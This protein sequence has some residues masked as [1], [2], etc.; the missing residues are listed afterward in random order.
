[1]LLEDHRADLRRAVLLAAHVDA[2]V[3]VGAGLDLV[4][5]DRLL[6]FDLSLLAAHEALDR[7]D[8][9]LGVHHRLPFGDGADQ[10]LTAVG[11]G[12]H[13]RGGAAP[14]RVLQDGWLAALHDGD[15]GVGRA[16]V[17]ADRLS[18]FSTYL[19]GFRYSSVKN[20]SRSMADYSR[21]TNPA[22]DK[23]RHV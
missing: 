8:R 7:E 10:A 13:R 11:E 4:G 5:D 9:V 18:H 3:A 21:N 20:L 1:Q 12:D 19:Q 2:D 17:D 23:S 15:T 6:L 22:R 14:L 16:E